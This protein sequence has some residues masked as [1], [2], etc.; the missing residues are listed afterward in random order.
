MVGLQVL[1]Q[2]LTRVVMVASLAP[3]DS[4]LVLTQ[5]VV[6]SCVTCSHEWGGRYDV[7][8]ALGLCIS[9]LLLLEHA[10]LAP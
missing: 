8:M 10:R 3:R 1:L 6:P 9:G 7:S 4:H 2:V 5:Y